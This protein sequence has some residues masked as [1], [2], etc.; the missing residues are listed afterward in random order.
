MIRKRP[1]FW[2]FSLIFYLFCLVFVNIIFLGRYVCLWIIVQIFQSHNIR[3]YFL[4]NVHKCWCFLILWRFNIL[5]IIMSILINSFLKTIL[6]PTLYAA[7]IMFLRKQMCICLPVLCHSDNMCT[8]M[9]IISK[10]LFFITYTYLKHDFSGENGGVGF[11]SGLLQKLLG[12]RPTQG[13]N[14]RPDVPV[15]RCIS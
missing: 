5:F 2:K 13:T 3:N 8:F 15:L 11:Q 14:W 10:I 9:W 4:V 1:F 6:W 12:L 7:V